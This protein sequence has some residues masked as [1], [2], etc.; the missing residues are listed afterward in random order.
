VADAAA[1]LDGLDVVVYTPS[2][3]FVPAAPQDIDPAV[4]Q[5][6]FDVIVHG[7]FQVASAAHEEFAQTRRGAPGAVLQ[8]ARSGETGSGDAATAAPRVCGVIVA[9][10]DLLATVPFAAFAAHCAAK[11]AQVM[12]V[13]AL[14]KAWAAEGIRVC[15]VAPGPVDLADDPRREATVRAAARTPLGRPVEPAEIAAAV[16]FAI[17]NDGLT[18]VN[19]PVDGG[20]LLT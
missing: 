18:G 14:A 20:A 2:G 1:V 7:F 15:G 6:S 13:R 4:Y 10:T 3:P 16:R 12:L 11:A 19:L 9:I 8:A 17:E 5:A